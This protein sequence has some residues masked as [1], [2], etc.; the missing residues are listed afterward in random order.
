MLSK[1]HQPEGQR[2]ADVICFEKEYLFSF[3]QIFKED[4]K[5]TFKTTLENL[6]LFPKEEY[7]N[8]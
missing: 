7:D 1:G 6:I 4:E 2:V 5:M 8:R 3:L